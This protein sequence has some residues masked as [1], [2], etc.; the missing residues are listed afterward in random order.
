MFY[1]DFILR[2]ERAFLIALNIPIVGNILRWLLVIENQHLPIIRLTPDAVNF[3]KGR[4]KRVAYC[5]VSNSNHFGRNLRDAFGWLFEALHWWDM[6]VANRWM[7]ALNVGLDTYSEQPDETAGVDCYYRQ[8][9]PNTNHNTTELK[10][11]D[12]SDNN[13]AVTLIKFDF[14]APELAGAII[15]PGSVVASLWYFDEAGA[16]NRTYYWR[17]SLRDWV[18]NQ[19]T[20]TI[21]KTSNNW[22][23]AGGNNAED[24]EA[25]ASAS[26]AITDTTHN[27]RQWTNWTESD[28]EPMLGPSGVNNGFSNSVGDNQGEGDQR[29]FRSSA[30]TTASQRPKMVFEYTAGV[31]GARPIFF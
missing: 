15:T 12:N 7:P 22:A 9:A 13:E 26:L 11:G 4:R 10:I 2:H 25:T 3:W 6:R 16:N 1:R 23:T 29:F 19:A 18:E 8:L 20:W 31:A 21:W 17:K 27:E 5:Y 24:R 30:Y 28:L 14:S